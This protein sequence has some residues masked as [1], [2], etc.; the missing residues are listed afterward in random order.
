MHRAF[1]FTTAVGRVIVH[2]F[3]GLLISMLY[4]LCHLS[5]LFV[6]Q[7][8]FISVLVDLFSSNQDDAYILKTAC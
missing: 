6:N 7:I 1:N 5:S 4:T 2:I 3:A 8:E